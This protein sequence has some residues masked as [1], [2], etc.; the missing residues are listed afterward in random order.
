MLM[1]EMARTPLPQAMPESWPAIASSASCT[2]PATAWC[3]EPDLT[4]VL[5]RS[6]HAMPAAREAIGQA[7][8][9]SPLLD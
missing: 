6:E 5:A 4:E 1:A 8:A 2:E 7:R 9:A 3:A